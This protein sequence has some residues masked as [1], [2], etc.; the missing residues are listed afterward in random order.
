MFIREDKTYATLFLQF[1][2]GILGH[3]ISVMFYTIWNA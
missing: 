2:Y 3:I 1:I